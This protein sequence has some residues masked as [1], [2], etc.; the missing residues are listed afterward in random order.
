VS[1]A[2]K[3]IASWHGALAVLS[4]VGCGASDAPVAETPSESAGSGGME[5]IVG[6]NGGNAG[7][8]S[9]G[10]ASGE[11]SISSSGAAGTSAG[12]GGATGG[13]GA[14]GTGGAAGSSNEAEGGAPHVVG[15]CDALPAKGTWQ[16]TTPAEVKAKFPKQQYGV[17]ALA[18]NPKNPAVVYF[19]THQIGIWK[20]TNCGSTW[21]HINTGENGAVLDGG[22]QWSVA[23]DPV[24][25]DVLYANSGYSSSSGAWKSTNGGVDWKALWPPADPELAKVV[26]YNFVHKIRIDPYDHQHLLVSFHAACN[27]PYNSACIAESKD[28]GATWKIVNG[29]ASWSGGEDQTVWFLYNSQTWLYASQSNGMWRTGD[30]GATWKMIDAA[31]G[32]HNGGQLYRAKNG[33]FYHADPAAGVLRSPDGITWSRTTGTGRGTIGLTGDGS[34][35]YASH[36]PYAEDPAYLPYYSS[37]ESDG[38]AWTRLTSPLLSTGGYELAYDP[39]HHLL[40]STNATAGFWR[41]V[42]E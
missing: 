26:Q 23:L 38:Q 41:V 42:V 4:A 7:P 11:G 29:S 40:Y 37:S 39:D 13:A 21:T 6:G 27:A 33:V 30:G 24:N 2:R 5:P 35:L 18:M 10:G 15:A 25:P 20:S 3:T 14:R 32:A 16:E 1:S 34:H 12:H 31:W 17:I 8:S 22:F 36:G 19:G 9:E 28:S